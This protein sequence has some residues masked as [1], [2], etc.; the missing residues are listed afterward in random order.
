MIVVRREIYEIAIG[1]ACGTVIEQ[2]H[3]VMA[4][5]SYN[6]PLYSLIFALAAGTCLSSASLAQQLT[7]KVDAVGPSAVDANEKK[8]SDNAS[9]TTA[10]ET[11]VVGGSGKGQN[12]GYQPVSTSSATRVDTPILDIPQAV[13][14]VSEQV[15]ED[16][17][18]RSLD[19]ALQNVSGITQA[20]TLGSTQDSFI[21]R[22]FGDNRDGS[23]MTNGL[24]T[25]LPRSFNA[26]TES[27]E[28]LKG[29]A[30]TL[31]GILDPSGVVNVN[32]KKPMQTFGGEIS[33]TASS[34]G[35]GS[36]QID[37]T[38]PIA[39]TNFAYRII[40]EYENLEYWRNFGKTKEWLIAPSLSWFGEQ[41]EATLSYMH[42]DYSTPF[43]RG[44]VFDLASGK[45]VDV[46]RKIR[47]DEPFNITDG[48]SDLAMLNVKHEM[49][50]GW[51]VNFDYA[52]SRNAYSD[53]QARVTGYN[54]TTG[55]LTRRIDA[56]QGSTI[57]NHSVRLDAHGNVEV[58][59]F[60]NELLIGGQ[61]DHYDL[62][63]TDMIRCA[64]SVDFNIYDPVYGNVS[65]CSTVRPAESD[66]TEKL[67]TASIYIQDSLHLNDQWILVGGVRYQHYDQISGR[68]R[69]FVLNTDTQGGKLVPRVGL[70][71]KATENLS[72]YA[73]YAESFK[74][75][76]SFSSYFGDL[77]PEEGTTYEVGAKYELLNGLTANLAIYTTDKRNV[78][79]FETIDGVIV[80]KAAGLV[81]ARGLE[82]DVAGQ[83]TNNLSV[84]ASYAYTDAQVKDDPDYSGKWPVN[85]AK[86]TFSLSGAYDFG[87]VWGENTLKVG[88]GIRGASKRA[89]VNDN[90]YFL[91]GYAVVD[92]FAAYTFATERPVTLQLNLRNLFDKT[93]YT[94]SQGANQYGNL[95]GEPFN[96]TLTMKVKL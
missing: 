6:R 25:A 72:F 67:K 33:T 80:T 53:N 92:A 89:G 31:Y 83:V 52:Y 17:N 94:S 78:S 37:L 75:Q 46:D 23:V 11:I 44:T 18:A 50:N 9:G 84:I 40:G 54:S 68:G 29:P 82:L 13:N 64:P 28:V 12:D 56:T 3:A 45:A 41:T 74:P 7:Q 30:S 35:G 55:D 60:D 63:R 77:P 15:L 69:P 73:N 87:E 81:R 26:T 58:A 34:I 4:L 51:T 95:I 27:V 59:G 5:R 90:A 66:Q 70:V 61:Y 36:G 62:L 79:Y 85:I 57:T 47:F 71:Y 91:P 48:K 20:N 93:Y 16:Q 65:T 10:L 96:A 21:R 24:K 43:D 42:Q 38:G 32:T 86:H 88:A 22:G 39:G 8:S 14:V 1:A 2:R 19:D 49:D 76:S